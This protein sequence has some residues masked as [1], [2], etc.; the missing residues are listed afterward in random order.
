MELG[1]SFTHLGGVWER[2][3]P[4]PGL[5]EQTP[6]CWHV[7]SETQGKAERLG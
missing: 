1:L 3:D 7:P 4:V 2:Q 6:P 5:R